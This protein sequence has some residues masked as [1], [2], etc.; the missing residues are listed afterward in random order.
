[1][2]YS[3]EKKLEKYTKLGV[4]LHKNMLSPIFCQHG[5]QKWFIR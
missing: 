4:L 3:R 5:V 1:V 2:G